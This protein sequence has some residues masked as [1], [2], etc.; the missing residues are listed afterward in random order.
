MNQLDT[1]LDKEVIAE[2]G[3]MFEVAQKLTGVEKQKDLL[4]VALVAGGK[5]VAYM[6]LLGAPVYAQMNVLGLVYR[7]LA[8]RFVVVL[9]EVWVATR[10]IG[11][12]LENVAPSDRE[13]RKE[14][15]MIWGF[16]PERE[17][18][19]EAD[20]ERDAE[21]GIQFGELKRLDEGG[22][23]MMRMQNP[24]K[25]TPAVPAELAA[26]LL[27]TLGITLT[28]GKPGAKTADADADA[29]LQNVGGL[30]N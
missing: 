15:L 7:K 3:R 16:T 5:E 20:M 26:T 29:L 9:S 2:C 12:G 30:P 6:P 22:T 11:D 27:E 17:I 19:F 13:D 8:A 21:G 25:T 1:D 4:P 24:C 14:K 23:R 18:I 28:E 10:N